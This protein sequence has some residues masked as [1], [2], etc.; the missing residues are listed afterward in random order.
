MCFQAPR[1]C[2]L[3]PNHDGSVGGTTECHREA[4][5]ARAQKQC[6]EGWSLTTTVL[7]SEMAL[8]VRPIPIAERLQCRNGHLT[9][10]GQCVFFTIF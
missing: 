6:W 5:P 7:G 10:D 1:C 9:V 4:R 8:S 3:E 2:L